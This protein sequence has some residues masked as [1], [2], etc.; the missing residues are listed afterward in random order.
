MPQGN[1]VKKLKAKRT[2]KENHPDPKSRIAKKR[3]IY[4]SVATFHN[5]GRLSVAFDRGVHY[6]LCCS[7]DLKSALEK[8]MSN[9]HNSGIQTQKRIRNEQHSSAEE[10]YMP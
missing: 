8:S 3:K 10:I 2:L 5:K 6:N 1:T 7:M 4:M 9:K